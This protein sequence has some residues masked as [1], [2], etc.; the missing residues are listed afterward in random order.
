MSPL[1]KEILIKGLMAGTAVQSAKKTSASVGYY[2]AAGV[3]AGLAFVFFAIAGYGWLLQSYPMHVAASITGCGIA[4]FSIFIGV[5]G[6]YR[7]NRK[8]IKKPTIATDG[9]F[10]DNVENTLKSLMGGFEEPIKDNPKMALLMAAL[11]G[12]AAGDHIGDRDGKYH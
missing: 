7:V 11:A 3:V 4:L 8:P 12:F 1:I 9:S 5:F 6:H 10:L 2:A